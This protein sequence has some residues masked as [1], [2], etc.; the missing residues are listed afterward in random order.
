MLA[1]IGV[2][3]AISPAVMPIIGGYL[4]A[5]FGWQANFQFLSAVAGSVLLAVWW[6]L[7]ETVGQP[8][9]RATRPSQIARTFVLLLRLRKFQGF[10]L[11]VAFIFTGLMA[12][13]A[14]AAFPVVDT[15]GLSP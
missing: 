2:A 4:Q 11:I 9:S 15:L 1:Y 10:M 12:Y 7:G 5:W 3:F 13:T 14:S 6:M 8:D